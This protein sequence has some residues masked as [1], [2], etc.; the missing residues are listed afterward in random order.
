METVGIAGLLVIGFLLGKIYERWT[1]GTMDIEE[2]AYFAGRERGYCEGYEDAKA[3][4]PHNPPLW[5]MRD[6]E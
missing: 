1:S 4:F 2:T 3:G 6:M 5:C